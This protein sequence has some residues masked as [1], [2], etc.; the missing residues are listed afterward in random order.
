M[1][2]TS[3]GQVTIP[4]AIRERYGIEPDSD[5][6]FEETPR[7]PVLVVQDE[8]RREHMRRVVRRMRGTSNTGLTTDEIMTMMRGEED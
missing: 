4:V 3:K 6:E 7:G 5:I 1:R 2:V 8:A